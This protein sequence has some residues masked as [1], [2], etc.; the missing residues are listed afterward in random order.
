[1]EYRLVGAAKGAV[2]SGVEQDFRRMP[3]RDVPGPGEALP[4]RRTAQAVTGARRHA[5]L[6]RGMLDAAAFG[7]RGDEILLAL[8][9]PAVLARLAAHRD[10]FV[11]GGIEAV[12]VER[13]LAVR[14]R[15]GLL[16]RVLRHQ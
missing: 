6:H 11:V 4:A 5:D 10:P 2:E 12:G 15:G 13:W 3:K 14:L 8:R 7:Q 1:I 16:R 9:R